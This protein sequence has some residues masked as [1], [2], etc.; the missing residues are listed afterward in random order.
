MSRNLPVLTLERL[1]RFHGLFAAHGPPTC[2]LSMLGTISLTGLRN[3]PRVS[4]REGVNARYFTSQAST[5][6]LIWQ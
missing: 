4:V 3:D 1:R 6:N 5:A 2:S